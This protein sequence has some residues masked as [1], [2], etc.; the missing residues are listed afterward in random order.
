M[1]NVL[2][3]K[4]DAIIPKTLLSVNVGRRSLGVI[5]RGAMYS[6]AMQEE[7]KRAVELAS[8]EHML[9]ALNYYYK[10]REAIGL[11]K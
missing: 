3:F 10:T 9:S 1:G 5:Q 11:V 4:S 8:F 6:V 2:K 7:G